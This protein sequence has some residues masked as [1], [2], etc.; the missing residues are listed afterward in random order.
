MGVRGEGELILN[1][2]VN[3]PRKYIMGR[4]MKQRTIDSSFFFFPISFGISSLVACMSRAK[5]PRRGGGGGK[6]GKEN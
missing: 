4:A 1:C 2:P 5:F 3:P 6:I